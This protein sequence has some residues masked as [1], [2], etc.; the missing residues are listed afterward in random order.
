MHT[1][2][3]VAHSPH[4]EEVRNQQLNTYF[5]STYHVAYHLLRAHTSN[6]QIH[7]RYNLRKLDEKRRRSESCWTP[8]TLSSMSSK[9]I[10]FNTKYLERDTTSCFVLKVTCRVN[11]WQPAIKVAHILL[12]TCLKFSVSGSKGLNILCRLPRLSL[13]I[14]FFLIIC[15]IHYLNYSFQN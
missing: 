7:W 13:K 4:A 10:G 8:F 11:A 1:F 6:K 3:Y 2:A 14:F 15:K 5:R 12:I 9:T